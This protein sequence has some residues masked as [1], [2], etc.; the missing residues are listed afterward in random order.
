MNHV[1]KVTRRGVPLQ[2]TVDV[3]YGLLCIEQCRRLG[4][5]ETPVTVN[6]E[7][8]IALLEE[9]SAIG[10]EPR[11]TAIRDVVGNT[12]VEEDLELVL[13]LIRKV[14]DQHGD[15]RVA[16]AQNTESSQGK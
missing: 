3:A 2:H 4:Y 15:P 11:G 14:Q 8:T 1:A 12:V 16:L 5:M 10:T 9:A 6:V 7:S 13:N